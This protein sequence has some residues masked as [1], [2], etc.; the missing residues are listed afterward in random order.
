MDANEYDSTI[1]AV[2]K[3]AMDLQDG[4]VQVKPG[5]RLA[6][7]RGAGLLAQIGKLKASSRCTAEQARACTAM[8]R[9]IRPE[10]ELG[11]I[12]DRLERLLE[13]EPVSRHGLARS[14]GACPRGCGRPTMWVSELGRDILRDAETDEMHYESCAGRQEGADV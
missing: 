5:E 3:R 12:V 9:A 6:P 8:E 7:A 4:L 1:E 10:D 14:A 13:G 11:R 2:L